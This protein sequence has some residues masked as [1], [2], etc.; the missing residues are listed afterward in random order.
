MESCFKLTEVKVGARTISADLAL[1]PGA[2]A[3]TS[4]NSEGTKRVLDVCPEVVDHVCLGDAAPHFGAV[5]E[6]TE[7]AHLLEHVTVELL[8][9]TDIAGDAVAGQTRQL[10]DGTFHITFDCPDDVLV[11]GALASALWVLDWAYGDVDGATPDIDLIASSLVDLVDSLPPVDEK[12]GEAEA[13]PEGAAVAEKLV[14]EEPVAEETPEV[15]ETTEVDETEEPEVAE[16]AEEVE[17]AEVETAED[18]E[19]PQTDEDAAATENEKPTSTSHHDIDGL[20]RPYL[21]R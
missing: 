15:A 20:P 18:E 19:E 4:D 16:E 6:D 17:A 5:A 8:A 13:E 12:D 14:E 21:V 10:D 9:K 1:N 7:L 3:R 2:P 11:A